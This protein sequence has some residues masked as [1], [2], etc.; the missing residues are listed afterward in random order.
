MLIVPVAA[1]EVLMAYPGPAVSVS[2]TVSLASTV[3]S[4]AGSM[5]TIA[6]VLPSA[7]LTVP[8]AAENDAAPDCA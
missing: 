3:V 1:S 6:V 5:V 7:K 8:V 2:T 4:A